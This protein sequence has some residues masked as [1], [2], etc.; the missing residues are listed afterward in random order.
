MTQT[1][2]QSD[3]GRWPVAAAIFAFLCNL[4]CVALLNYQNY[5]LNN[6]LV[7][8]Y[9]EI[10]SECFL[11]TPLLVAIIFHH[12]AAIAFTYALMLSA[13][14]A[15]RIYYL[16]QFYRIGIDAFVPK[17]DLP[18]LGLILLAGV[19]LLILLISALSFATAFI[20]RAL[21]RGDGVSS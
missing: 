15:G 7:L 8:N 11:L 21:K 5:L 14:L 6:A 18:G 10:F 12:V 20:G 19:S 3:V 2:A 4:L 1:N 13:I 9:P 17:M 16:V